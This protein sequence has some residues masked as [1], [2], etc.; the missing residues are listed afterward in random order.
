MIMFRAIASALVVLVT[1]LTFVGCE[2]VEL[3]V[4]VDV[5]K[6]K[7]ALVAKLKSPMHFEASAGGA[8]GACAFRRE[9]GRQTQSCHDISY[10]LTVPAQ[11]LLRSCGVQF[12]VHGFTMNGTWE[13]ALTEASRY[14]ADLDLITVQPTAV[15]GCVPPDCSWPSSTYCAEKVHN[16][17]DDVEEIFNTDRARYFMGGS[18]QGGGCSN[19]VMN[20]AQA[21]RFAAFTVG[22]SMATIPPQP[23]N[24]LWFTGRYDTFASVTPD[25]VVPRLN[26]F[27]QAWG[28]TNYT[29]RDAGRE[30]ELGRW[31][32]PS[33]FPSVEWFVH[34]YTAAGTIVGAVIGGHCAPGGLDGPTYGPPFARILGMELRLSCPQPDP[35]Q[36]ELGSWAGA[37]TSGYYNRHPKK[38]IMMKQ[39]VG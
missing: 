3:D 14:G 11:C 1:V 23:Q 15:D 16:A 39:I 19:A 38:N 35:K 2:L 32:H 29:L 17:L 13:E 21:S 25:R 36:A 20:G 31:E 18:L 22:A 5:E 8:A 7:L 28:L 6:V 9:A 26:Q 30:Y 27:I 4:G 12:D 37:V 34:N 10:D 33:G 24:F